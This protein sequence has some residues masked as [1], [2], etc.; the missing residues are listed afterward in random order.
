M[1]L[2]EEGRRFFLGS[3]ANANGISGGAHCSGRR[4]LHAV[5]GRRFKC[6]TPA[7]G[8]TKTCNYVECCKLGCVRRRVRSLTVSNELF[9]FFGCHGCSPRAA[10]SINRDSE[11][12]RAE[13][14]VAFC[15]T[16]P[17]TGQPPA[18]T[19][20]SIRHLLVALAGRGQIA[21]HIAGANATNDEH[22]GELRMAHV[23][24]IPDLR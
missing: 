6:S 20:R 14:F 5:L 7:A 24:R 18:A 2:R 22:V 12:V 21:F 10:F 16:L 1:L 15:R 13:P 17:L 19:S 11:A 3:R 23:M 9:V 8:T 4:P